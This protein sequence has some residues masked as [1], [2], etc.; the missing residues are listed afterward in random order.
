MMLH[1]ALWKLNSPEW[2]A[3]NV[4]WSTPS[5]VTIA[6]I[7]TKGPE[8]TQIA[9]NGRESEHRGIGRPFGP[10]RDPDFA[11]VLHGVKDV[12]WFRRVTYHVHVDIE[13]G[14]FFG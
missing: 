7:E 1:N 6:P 13:I 11:A 2:H 9:F 3:N 5:S 14:E 8:S 12:R 4:Q 10:D